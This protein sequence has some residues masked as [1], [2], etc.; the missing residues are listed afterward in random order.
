[1]MRISW[2]GP[3][4]LAAAAACCGCTT[5]QQAGMLV[6]P[7]RWPGQIMEVC[8]GGS[9]NLTASGRI[10]LQ[11]KVKAPD[12][13]EIDV[14]LIA[15]RLCEKTPDN[16]GGFLETKLTRGTVVL[17]HPLLAGKAWYLQLGEELADR[18]WD[19]VLMDSRG[20]GYSGG[21]YTTWGVREKTDVKAVV[22]KLLADRQI[23]DRI[24]ACGSS[25][26]GGV[27]IQYAA[28]DPRCKGVI[29]LAPP[30][31]LMGV[32]R[33]ILPLSPKD[34]FEAAVRQAGQMAGFNPAEASTVTAAQQLTCPVVVIRGG[35]G[36]VIPSNQ[37]QAVFDAVDGPKK[38]VTVSFAGS[39][40]DLWRDDWLAN[41][42][43]GLAAM[44]G[45]K[46][47]QA[48]AMNSTGR[49]DGPATSTAPATPP[50]VAPAA[51]DLTMLP[52]PGRFPQA[53][54]P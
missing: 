27:A 4:A 25:L 50:E 48:V 3:A 11:R 15:S 40:V 20:C 37:C 30:G 5:Q 21:E 22:D 29:A 45:D 8:A 19:V 35:L 47:P 41:Q 13:T 23:S 7:A 46:P 36:L 51:A 12:G 34:K 38:L 24:Y 44:Q 31:D 18:G 28:I 17:L 39:L 33:R 1:M 52:E 6:V 14:W 49:S 43:D 26:G 2:F 16:K 10:T 9:K 32:F 42:V 54:R 53:D